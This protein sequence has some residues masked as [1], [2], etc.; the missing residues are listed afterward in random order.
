MSAHGGR[1]LALSGGVGGARMAHGLMLALDDPSRLTVCCNVGDD[2]DHLGLRICPDIDTVLYTLSDL[3]DPVRGWGVR[4]E[5]WSFMA[6]LE[7]VGGET[8]FLLGDRDL[9][10]HV[11]RSRRLAAGE[12]LGAVTAA[13]A[14]NLGIGARVV[15]ATDDPTPTRVLTPDGELAF[16]HYFVREQCRPT[17]TG[18]RFQGAQSARL[19][20]EAGA[21]F[22]DPA[23]EAIVLCP[24]NPFLSLQPMLAIPELERRLRARRAPAVAVSPI[25]GGQA[26]KGPLA[27]IMVEQG[28]EVS[29][30]GI[31]RL[32]PGLI[33]GLM[34]D[35][36]DA[37]LAPD[38]EALGLRV[39]VGQT[40]MRDEDGRRALAAHALDFAARLAGETR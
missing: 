2:F 12:S 5:T 27:K 19:S 36:A 32:Y 11:E 24:S 10:V 39:H 34:I 21:A 3:A 17:L 1:I 18:L 30:L 7:R 37:S 15:P 38:I 6:A 35:E 14:A 25:I 26:V 16:Q 8:W 23:L 13:L 9:A 31:A 28:L 4:D 20:A 29:P 22:D 40:L 33:D